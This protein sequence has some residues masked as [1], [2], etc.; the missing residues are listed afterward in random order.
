[1][2][3]E[4]ALEIRFRSLKEIKEFI[5][6]VDIYQ[7]C[8]KQEEW[9]GKGYIITNRIYDSEGKRETYVTEPEES[10]VISRSG[11]KI[12]VTPYYRQLSWLFKTLYHFVEYSN[13][14]L[15]AGA[16][17]KG[18]SVGC[19]GYF[20]MNPSHSA[21]ELMLYVLDAIQRLQEYVVRPQAE[22]EE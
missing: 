11:D 22:K 15:G 20:V 9:G 21:K 4:I 1:M 7:L 14:Q 10:K 6:M 13:D 8:D 16:F 19:E 5:L 12:I 2:K 18:F 17:L 3:E